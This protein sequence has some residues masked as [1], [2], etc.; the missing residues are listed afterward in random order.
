[1]RKKE[2]GSRRALTD[3]LA[4]YLSIATGVL[5]GHFTDKARESRYHVPQVIP[6]ARERIAEESEYS[7]FLN[8]I[9]STGLEFYFP[10]NI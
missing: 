10:K 1:M 3:D 2:N 9:N 5:I 6:P 7:R 4:M 8:R